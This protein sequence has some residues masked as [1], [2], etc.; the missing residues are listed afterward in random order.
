MN[1][2]NILIVEDGQSQREMLRDFLIKEG[3]NV[4]EAESGE[5]GIAAVKT[6]HFDLLLLDY[7]MPGMNGLEVLEEVKK[8]NPDIDV[9]MMTAFGT[10]ETAVRAMKT[11]AADYITKPVE[12]EEL[13]L[14]L[15]RLSER[16]T[17]IREN[18]ILRHCRP[19][20]AVRSAAASPRVLQLSRGLGQHRGWRSRSHAKARGAVANSLGTDHGRRMEGRKQVLGCASPNAARTCLRRRGRRLAPRA[21]AARARVVRQR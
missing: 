2:L 18:E 3:H 17:L 6:G 4:E 11:G 16:R 20:G 9:I 13:L 15:S 1:K 12:L 21:G 14:H 7:K 8:I 5:K 19:A 10:I